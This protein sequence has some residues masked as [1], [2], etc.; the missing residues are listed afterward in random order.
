LRAGGWEQASWGG[1]EGSGNRAV[2]RATSPVAT[3]LLPRPWHPRSPFLPTSAFP[4]RAMGR[5]PTS[6]PWEPLAVP[7]SGPRRAPGVRKDRFTGRRAGTGAGDGTRRD[8]QR[9]PPPHKGPVPLV[10]PN[11]TV[12]FLG[13]PGK[14]PNRNQVPPEK[15]TRRRTFLGPE[16]KLCSQC[17]KVQI[18]H[19]FPKKTSQ[20]NHI[21]L[22]FIHSSPPPRTKNNT[23]KMV[24]LCLI[25]VA[26]TCWRL[27]R[28]PH[29]SV[30]RS[31]IPGDGSTQPGGRGARPGE[32]SSPLYLSR[33]LVRP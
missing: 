5:K 1:H 6:G 15:K 33:P 9:Y 3:P 21:R 20:P 24:A 32:D 22:S 7:R 11:R 26:Q 19:P 4:S 16:S 8:A 18:Q 30:P 23:M 25:A 31:T 27:W 17:F 2:A 28:I 14:I 12:C 29:L 13:P 10:S